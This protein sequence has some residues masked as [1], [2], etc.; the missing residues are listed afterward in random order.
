MI[1]KNKYSY[2]I[3]K[4]DYDCGVAASYALLINSRIET[5]KYKKL[6]KILKLSKN[7]VSYRSIA[8]FFSQIPHLEPKVKSRVSLDFLKSETKK[9]RLAIVAYQT[10]G[11]P[12]EVKKLICGHYSVVVK[13]YRNKV[14]LLDPA[15]HK[16]WGDGVG[17]R[18]LPVSEFNKLWIDREH[19]KI[20]RKWMVSVKPLKRKRSIK[21]A[22][23]R[24]L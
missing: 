22:N 12:H 14:Y 3:Q 17:W 13:V 20:V 16:D 24:N 5:I 6:E 9:G 15:A 4:K 2:V 18:I 23:W 21:F 1:N 11:K 8:S 7:G 19:G 10:W